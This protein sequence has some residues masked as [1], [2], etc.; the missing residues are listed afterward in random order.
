MTFTDRIG[1][2]DEPVEDSDVVRVRDSA[3]FEK[4]HV[5]LSERLDD[6]LEQIKDTAAE[7]RSKLT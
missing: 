7:E 1:R 4:D 2:F 5:D 6:D 3:I